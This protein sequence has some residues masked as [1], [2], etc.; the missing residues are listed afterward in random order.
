MGECGG[1]VETWLKQRQIQGITTLLFSVAEGTSLGP[2]NTDVLTWYT[3]GDIGGDQY[4][5]NEENPEDWVT[6]IE[7]FESGRAGVNKVEENGDHAALL[8]ELEETRGALAAAQMRADQAEERAISAEERAFAAEER[9]RVAEAKLSESLKS[10]AGHAGVGPPAL[11]TGGRPRGA[12]PRGARPRG[13]RPRG[14]PPLPARGGPRGGPKARATPKRGGGGGRGDLLAAIQAGKGLKS[15]GLGNLNR[16]QKCQVGRGRDGR[17]FGGDISWQK[18]E[19]GRIKKLKPQPLSKA[20]SG[21]G[22]GG[23]MMAM[24]QAK[25]A[26]RKKRAAGGI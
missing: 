5:S 20:T 11:H 7:F 16:S 1:C 9:A 24:I 26:A 25:A 6:A 23:G 22:G 21:G 13:A 15:A 17:S 2:F 8:V 4:V 19:E 14:A 18:V 3:S 10:G 12:R